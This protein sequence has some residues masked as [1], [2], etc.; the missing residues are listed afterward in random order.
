MKNCHI[1]E[2]RTSLSSL[3]RAVLVGHGDHFWRSYDGEGEGESVHTISPDPG[4]HGIKTA[5]FYQSEL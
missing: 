2:N 5:I 1:L 4:Y 3:Y